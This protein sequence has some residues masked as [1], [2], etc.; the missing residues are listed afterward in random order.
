VKIAVLGTR[1]IPANYG[2]FETFAEELSSRLAARGHEVVVYCRAH[3]APADAPTAP[4]VR[5]VV[6]PT[7]RRKHLDTL[8]H[9]LLS[10]VH[11][12]S[13]RCEVV[14]F[15]NAANALFLPLPRLGGAKVAINVDGLEWQRRKWGWAGRSFYRLS[16]RLSCAFSRRVVTDSRVIQQHYARAYG[17]AT[18]F[19]PYGTPAVP[20]PTTGALERYSLR[21][22]GY[23][24]YVARFEPEYNADKVVAAFE[25]VD[26]DKRLVMVGDAPYARE[27]VERVR[28]TK[29]PRVLFTGFLHGLG[30]RELVSHA[31]ACIQAAEVGGTHPALLEA[32]GMGRGLLVH[33]IPENREA[34]GDGALYFR[35]DR[36]PSLREALRL[37]LH[38]P[39]RLAAAAARAKERVRAHY[40][41]DAVTAAYESL[42]RELVEGGAVRRTATRAAG[43]ADPSG[44]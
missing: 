31:Y 41:W 26:T 18:E 30:Y 21:P 16:E 9:T 33:D 28:R 2:G 32:M 37:A 3:H 14:L 42:F 39:E 44:S 6:L 8:A 19:I 29:D 34:A 24:L 17:Q 20:V 1:G 23:F 13:E 43:V 27:F 35:F 15:C 4:G 38:D 7:L 36:E 12:L 25:A 22:G 11:V 5:R 10:A 40:D